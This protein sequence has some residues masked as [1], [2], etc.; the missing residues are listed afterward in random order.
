MQHD[1]FI[2]LVQQ[3]AKLS[4][5]G[6]AERATRAS[7]ETLGERI[8]EGTAEHLAAQLPHEIGEHLR[9]TEVYG[10]VG[11]GERFDLQEFVGRVARRAGVEPPRAAYFARVVFELLDEATQGGLMRK[12]RDSVPEDIRQLVDAGST[13]EMNVR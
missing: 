11:T 13:G 3:R 10:G 1:E 5:R 12:V 2:G 8:P 4:S 6:E 9:R 7:L